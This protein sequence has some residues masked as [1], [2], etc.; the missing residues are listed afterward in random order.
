MKCFHIVLRNTR[1]EL[2]SVFYKWGNWCPERLHNQPKF[3]T[4]HGS[5]SIMICKVKV[6]VTVFWKADSNGW[7]GHIV[8]AGYLFWKLW[9]SMLAVSQ[10]ININAH[11]TGLQNVNLF[12]M[13]TNYYYIIVTNYFPVLKLHTE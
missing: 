7:P 8:G 12:T 10:E 5:K 2:S 4:T 11:K 6:I 13:R 9:K 3:K 1:Q